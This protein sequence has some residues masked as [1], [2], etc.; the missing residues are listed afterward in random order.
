M[1]IIDKPMARLQVDEA[2]FLMLEPGVYATLH[3]EQSAAPLTAEL[4]STFGTVRLT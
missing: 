4:T 2:R 1:R 3:Y